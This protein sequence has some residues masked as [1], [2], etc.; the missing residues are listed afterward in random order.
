[1]RDTDAFGPW[2][3]E[4][5]RRREVLVADRPTLDATRSTR[6]A[7]WSRFAVRARQA[8]GLAPERRPGQESQLVCDHRR[9]VE[10]R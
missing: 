3:M 5:A 2:E 9:P 6:A 8:M 10:A 7:A 4:A 1:M